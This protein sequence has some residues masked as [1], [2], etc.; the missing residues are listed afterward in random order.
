[1]NTASTSSP[2]DAV[3]TIFGQITPSGFGTIMN[4]DPLATLGFL[5]ATGIRLFLSV[6][7]LAVLLYMLWGAFDWVM[8]GGEKTKIEK[9]QQ[10]IT[11]AII[12]FLVII[13]VLVLFGTVAGD[14]LGIVKREGGSWVINIPK[15]GQ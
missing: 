4:G 3:P 13:V 6:A 12:G 7:A 8:S 9:A 1:M 14:I 5:L 2:A 10:K 11:Q 15:F